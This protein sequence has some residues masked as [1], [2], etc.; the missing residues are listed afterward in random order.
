[1]VRL[2]SYKYLIFLGL[3]VQF[4]NGKPWLQGSNDF[5]ILVFAQSWPETVCYKWML[6]SS[7]NYCNMPESA[8]WSIHGLWPS[9]YKKMGPSSCDNSLTFDSRVLKNMRKNLL[10]K[11]IDVHGKRPELFWEHEYI[12]HGTCAAVLDSLNS[13]KKY[14]QKSLEL[15]DKYHMKN[16]LDQ[17][18]INPGRNHPVQNILDG[19]RNILG[20]NTQVACHKNPSTQEQFLLEIR[21]CFDKT[22]QLTDCDGIISFPTNCDFEID[23]IY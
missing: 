18:N 17:A 15:F 1:M 10:I 6:K 2:K 20:Y 11:W 23:V 7:G 5:D 13:Q 12:K 16:I 22:L 14:F 3:M 4:S 8:A 21:I 19:V 9:Q